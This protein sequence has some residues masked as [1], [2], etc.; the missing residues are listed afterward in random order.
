MK[1]KQTMGNLQAISV[2]ENTIT[3]GGSLILQNDVTHTN[4]A[5]FFF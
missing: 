1:S 5:V 3:A 4:K 2:E